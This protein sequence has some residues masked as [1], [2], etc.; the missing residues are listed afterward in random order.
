[1]E[2]LRAYKIWGD[3]ACNDTLNEMKYLKWWVSEPG[4]RTVELEELST[5]PKRAEKIFTTHPVGTIIDKC[6]L[7]DWL[8]RT[9][10]APLPLQY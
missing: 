9:I 6:R 2:Q 8:F 4:E 7:P 3:H 5:L 10:T 1:M